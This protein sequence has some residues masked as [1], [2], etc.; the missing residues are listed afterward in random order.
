MN[1]RTLLTGLAVL[2]LATSC[3]AGTQGIFASIE[4]EQKIVTTG[5]LNTAATVT[6]MAELI[7]SAPSTGVLFVS[8]GQ[9]LFSKPNT[10]SSGTW[11]T[12][13]VD[14]HGNVAAVGVAGS[15]VY[16]VAG[17]GLYQST[18]GSNWTA[19]SGLAS[20]DI[21]YDLIPV[22]NSDGVTNN[23]L[24]LVT[25]ISY[26]DPGNSSATLYQFGRI[27]MITPSGIN[28]TPFILNDPT[29]SSASTGLGAPVI[30]AATNGTTSTAGTVF[31]LASTSYLWCWNGSDSATATAEAYTGGPVNTN[32][33]GL[34]YLGTPYQSSTVINQLYVATGIKSGTTSGGSLYVSTNS[35]APLL[36]PGGWTTITSSLS[37]NSLP[38]NFGQ[39]LYNTTNSSLWIATG[40]TTGAVQ[41]GT[42]Y[43]ELTVP[44][45][46]FSTTPITNS[47]N[48]SSSGLYTYAVGCLFYSQNG[49]YYLGTRAHGLWYWNESGNSSN[50]WTQD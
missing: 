36:S 33:T 46:S 24:I 19:T 22:R 2:I 1:L 31:Y 27:Y 40:N 26:T 12:S 9:A 41:Q 37:Y 29:G 35:T 38:V 48:Y 45:N 4:Q 50:P 28:L 18:D 49:Y 11:G 44:G 42:G 16:A 17:G 15:T 47:S 23:D 43:M 25:M 10:V 32:Y 14:Q 8:G 34:I 39:F 30:S 3:T 20:G 21:P 5:N 13:S 7:T 6:R